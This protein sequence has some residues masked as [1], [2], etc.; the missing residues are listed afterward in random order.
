MGTNSQQ[1]RLPVLFIWKKPITVYVDEILSLLICIKR[2]INCFLVLQIILRMIL[3]WKRNDSNE[4][5]YSIRWFRIIP[6]PIHLRVVYFGA[7][8]RIFTIITKKGRFE[9]KPF[10]SWVADEYKTWT[11]SIKAGCFQDS[12]RQSGIEA[13]LLNKNDHVQN[14]YW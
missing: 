6:I 2:L 12:E 7:F 9:I 8:Q 13:V 3:L 4:R 1:F 11:W 5:V 10:I 14:Y